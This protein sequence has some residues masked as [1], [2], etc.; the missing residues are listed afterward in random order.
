M[1]KFYNWY[2]RQ[3]PFVKALIVAVLVNIVLWGTIIAT[4]HAYKFIFDIY[5]K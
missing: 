3:K 4:H 1:E 2:G 5:G